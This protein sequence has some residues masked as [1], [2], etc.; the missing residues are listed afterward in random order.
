M[1]DP[2]AHP[3][4]KTY[5]APRWMKVTLVISL[6][7]NLLIVGAVAGAVLTKGDPPGARKGGAGN[8]GANMVTDALPKEERRALRREVRRTLRARPDLRE[9]LHTEIAA[10]ADLMRAPDY[11]AGA[12]EAQLTQIQ[13]RMMGPLSVARSVLAERLT[14]FNASERASYADRLDRLLNENRR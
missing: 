10:L 4:A 8:H 11:T 13:M 14:D 2:V 9:A 6:A 1:T 12:L 5:R 3:D 7:V